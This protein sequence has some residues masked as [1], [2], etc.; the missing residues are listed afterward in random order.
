VISGIRQM[1]KSLPRSPSAHRRRRE[2]DRTDN[3]LWLPQPTQRGSGDQ[4]RNHGAA[5]DTNRV[6]AFSLST[7]RRDDID[8]NV[9]RTKLLLPEHAKESQVPVCLYQADV[10]IAPGCRQSAVT[11]IFI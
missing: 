6:R 5:E 1:Q 3:I 8:P 9:P 7:T 10:D 11:S 4:A 2:H